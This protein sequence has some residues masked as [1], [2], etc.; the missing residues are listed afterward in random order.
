MNSNLFIINK[1][2]DLKIE[3]MNDKIS[4]E[5]FFNENKKLIYSICWKFKRKNPNIEFEDLVSESNLAFLRA[6]HSFDCNKNIKFSTY[7]Y[8]II[9]NNLIVF[10][11][12]ENRENS[13]K[14]NENINS[15]FN[16]AFFEL[17]NEC[18]KVTDFCYKIAGYQKPTKQ[19]LSYVMHNNCGY[20]Y[21]EIYNIF[22]E[23]KGALI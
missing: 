18:K 7:L 23:I 16:F 13:L 5:K 10:C 6:Y 21:K 20:K 9:K 4:K 19:F 22:N 1:I 3:K 8:N 14:L 15:N 17:S 2:K 11:R 12:Y